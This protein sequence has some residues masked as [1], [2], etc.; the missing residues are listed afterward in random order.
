MATLRSTARIARPAADVWAVVSDAGTISTW[1]PDIEKSSADA[2]SRSC[3]LAGGTVLDEDIVTNDAALRRFQYRIHPGA[4]P[5]EQHLGTVDVIEVGPA[6]TL[7][8]YSTEITP[9]SL[10]RVMGPSIEAGVQ[11]LKATLE[12]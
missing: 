11:G 7:V 3:T 2:T 1:F 8:V 6:D 12:S 5:V 9:D 10:S 4:L